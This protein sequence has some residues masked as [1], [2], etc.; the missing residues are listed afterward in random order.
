MYSYFWDSLYKAL[1]S[2]SELLMKNKNP[3]GAAKF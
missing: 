1:T 2:P 3:S